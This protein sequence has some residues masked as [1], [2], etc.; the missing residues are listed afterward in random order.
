[1]ILAAYSFVAIGWLSARRPGACRCFHQAFHLAGVDFA[2]LA[3]VGEAAPVSV[4][5]ALEHYVGEARF[6]L[7]L[8]DAAQVVV[9]RSFVSRSC[10]F[11][12]ICFDPP[13][14][15]AYLA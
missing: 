9:E 7:A 6:A 1:M 11:E 8:S 4:H 12:R 14:S 5:S 13:N 10:S 15:V 2:W 3:A